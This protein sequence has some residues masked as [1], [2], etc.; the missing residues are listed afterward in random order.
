VFVATKNAGSTAIDSTRPYF[1]KFPDEYNNVKLRAV[2]RPQIISEYFEA[3][4]CIDRHNQ[5]RQSSLKLEKHWIRTDGWFRLDTTLLGID[6]TDAWKAY[7]HGLGDKK[8]HKN[9]TSVKYADRVAYQILHYPWCKEVNKPVSLPSL[10][11]LNVARDPSDNSSLPA[12]INTLSPDNMSALSFDS[13]AMTG[14]TIPVPEGCLAK[15][16]ERYRKL[17]PQKRLGYNEKTKRNRRRDCVMKNCTSQSAVICD[18]CTNVYCMDRVSG[19]PT[20]CCYYAHICESWMTSDEMMPDDP[21]Y[22]A[23]AQ[24]NEKRKTKAYF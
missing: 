20:K 8:R 11:P 24:W 7:C 2:D 6:V 22:A 23:Y 17:H 15:V 3:S 4:N 9:I 14:S 16:P 10:P 13:A 19:A 1:A 21:F 12:S 18:K 5:A